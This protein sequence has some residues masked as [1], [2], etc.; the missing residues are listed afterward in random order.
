MYFI[1]AIAEAKIKESERK[2]EFDNLS[3]NGRP[4]NY[5]D[6]SMIPPDLRMA[7]KALKNAGY[8]PPEMQ[9]RKDIHSAL[10][11]LEH[12]EDEKKRYLQMQKVNLLFEQVKSMRGTKIS[13][14]EEDEY[15]KSIVERMTLHSKKFKEIK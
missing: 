2:G 5:E 14:D 12:M 10:D 3:C 11:L 9:L 6:D 15:Y 8:L 7:Y 1:S 4:I 13:I